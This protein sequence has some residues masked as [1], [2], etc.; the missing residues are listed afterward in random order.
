M[1]QLTLARNVQKKC[2]QSTAITKSHKVINIKYYIP[3]KGGN[4]SQQPPD[5]RVICYIAKGSG[6][7]RGA[8][9]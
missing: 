7:G 2:K 8:G 6:E 9:P 5:E 1:S 4:E 3:E